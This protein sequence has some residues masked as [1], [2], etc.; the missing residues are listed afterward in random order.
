MEVGVVKKN[1]LITCQFGRQN[2]FSFVTSNRHKIVNLV[3][4]IAYRIYENYN[5]PTW[6]LQ[7]NSRYLIETN[8]LLFNTKD[9]DFKNILI[10][11]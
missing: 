2:Y 9:R 4:L 5:D 10:S 1:I 11:Q 6:Y 7:M 3:N 8:I